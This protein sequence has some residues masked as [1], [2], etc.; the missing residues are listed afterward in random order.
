MLLLPSRDSRKAAETKCVRK[1]I[2]RKRLPAGS[3]SF[4]RD[5]YGLMIW[6]SADGYSFISKQVITG[7]LEGV[8]KPLD[9][10]LVFFLIPQ[11][12]EDV[13]AAGCFFSMV[14][15]QII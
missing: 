11:N 6:R 14:F 3:L 5:W 12:T 9:L 2:H 4:L 10:C 13:K 15:I 1:S 8:R 7:K